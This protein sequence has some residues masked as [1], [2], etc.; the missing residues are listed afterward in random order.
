MRKKLIAANWKMYKTPDQARDFFRDFLPLVPDHDR[1]EIVVCPNYLAIDVAVQ[2]VGH[3]RRHRR[4]RSALGKR[5]RLHR[6][7]LHQHAD[8][9]R[10]D[11]RHHRTLRAPPVFRRDRRHRQ[12]QTQSP[13]SKPDSFPSSASAKCSKSA[14][15]DSP[16]TFSAAS[17]CAPSTRFPP[18]KP[19]NWSSP[20][21]PSGPSAP[22]RL[23]RPEIAADAHAI[24]R[25]EAAQC[26]RPGIRRQT[27]HPLRRLGQTRQR[28]RP[29]VRGR[30]RRRPGRRSVAR[31][32]VVRRNCEVLRTAVV[33]GLRPASA[34]GTGS[35]SKRGRLWTPART[36]RGRVPE[37]LEKHEC[38]PRRGRAAPSG[39]R[40]SPR[41]N[42]GF[43]PGGR[44]SR[45]ERL[46]KQT[47]QPL[48][49]PAPKLA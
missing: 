35:D 44:I 19:G 13:P 39:P 9:R 10:R 21:N 49:S 6:R 38:V 4:A 8:R 48:R 40:K 32:Q 33:A 42:A 1:D 36:G 14:K 43:S 23:Q 18:R 29:D 16:T 7:N 5:R 41:I 27:P 3:Q 47:V 31:S 2:A 30:D 45:G 28:P 15:P 34:R 37:A 46:F 26:L 11:A 12:P 22:A 24:I 25:S 17:A 20:T